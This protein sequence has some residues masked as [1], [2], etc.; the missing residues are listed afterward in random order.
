MSFNL[1]TYELRLTYV[2][3]LVVGTFVY[4]Y[5]GALP[6]VGAVIVTV[7]IGLGFEVIFGRRY[8][9]DVLPGEADPFFPAQ[10]S[11]KERLLDDFSLVGYTILAVVGISM[12]WRWVVIILSALTLS[13]LAVLFGFIKYEME[14]FKP[15]Q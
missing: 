11:L 5:G 6:S 8:A 4:S 1:N 10:T 15:E 12:G 14:Q 7:V 3:A 13:V 2:V 9:F